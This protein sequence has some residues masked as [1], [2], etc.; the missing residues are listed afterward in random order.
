VDPITNTIAP[1]QFRIG[2]AA[3]D[4]D[5]RIIYDDTTGAVFFDADGT[6]A[7]AAIQF[8]IVDPGLAL[9]NSQFIVI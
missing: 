9:T 1:Q 3:Q 6:G 4:A 2:A 7:A 8:A 5:D